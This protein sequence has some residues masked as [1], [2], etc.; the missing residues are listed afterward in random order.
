MTCYIFGAAP[1][2][3]RFWMK[4]HLHL[5]E[6]DLLICADGG[7]HLARS[8]GM[9]PDWLVG[10]F[11]SCGDLLEAPPFAISPERIV[12]FDPQKDD[13]DLALAIQLGRLIGAT[14][15]V[16]YG[17][18]GG[19]FDHEMA[20]VQ[21]LCGLISDPLITMVV[22]GPWHSY[23][24]L[25]NRSLTVQN[26]DLDPFDG[27]APASP[28]D[29]MG[30]RTFSVFSLEPQSRGVSITGAAYPLDQATLCYDRPLGVSNEVAAVSATITVT[31]GTLLIVAEQ[32]L[33][34]RAGLL[35]RPRRHTKGPAS[36][37]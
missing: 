24:C 1:M 13:T 37:E 32:R 27:V 25:R 14:D 29:R 23:C 34:Q 11:D 22:E 10:D 21:L 8:L 3:E 19:R 12:R 30:R 31:Q 35:F 18:T 36:I 5:Q 2:T 16:F 4:Q 17:V 9:T 20:V 28:N 6:D 7:Y 15:F 26:F 33:D